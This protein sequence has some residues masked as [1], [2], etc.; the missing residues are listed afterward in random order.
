MSD[1][2]TLAEALEEFRRG[3]REQSGGMELKL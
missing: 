1:K 2:D 3:N